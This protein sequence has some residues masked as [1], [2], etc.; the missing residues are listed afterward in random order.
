MGELERLEKE[1]TKSLVKYVTLNDEYKAKLPPVNEDIPRWVPDLESIMEL[2]R[3][4]RE[5]E[6]ARKEWS[7]KLKEYLQ[8]KTNK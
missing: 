1:V 7:S 3:M 6:E 5:V 4:G 8:K 2:D